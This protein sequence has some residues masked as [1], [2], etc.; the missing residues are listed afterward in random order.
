MRKLKWTMLVALAACFPAAAVWADMQA[1]PGS[2]TAGQWVK[3]TAVTPN[4]AKV[5]VPPGY[6]VGVFKA[7]LDTPSSAAVDKDGNLWV[8]ISGPLFNTI[9]TLE[10]PH[11]KIF[12]PQ[13]N[14]ILSLIHI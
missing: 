7:G 10:P 14:L 6:K 13:G 4:P 11:V 2:P 1:Q 12:D 5:V 3:R 8:A 9:D